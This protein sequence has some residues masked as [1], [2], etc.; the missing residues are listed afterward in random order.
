MTEPPKREWRWL[1]VECGTE[2]RGECPD[3]CPECL[4]PDAWY[5][6]NAHGDDPTHMQAIFRGLFSILGP[7]H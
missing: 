5:E 3:V 4:C 7:R 1:C 2:G 6:T